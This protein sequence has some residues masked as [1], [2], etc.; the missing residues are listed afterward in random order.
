MSSVHKQY[1]TMLM[2]CCMHMVSN[3]HKGLAS[4]EVCQH[5]YW[6]LGQVDVG[7]VQV[8][9]LAEVQQNVLLILYGSC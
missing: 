2:H 5:L 7:V 9:K 8:I 3:Q 6:L 1:Q 4:K